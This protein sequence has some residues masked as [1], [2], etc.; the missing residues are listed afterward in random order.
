M[1]KRDFYEVLGVAKGA[2][3]KALKSAFRKQAMKYHPDR[4]PDDADA[5]AKFKEVNEAYGILSDAQKRAA[6]DRMGHAAFEGGMGSGGMGGGNPFGGGRSG[7]F[8]GFGDIFEEMFGGSFG[9]RGRGGRQRQQR[10]ADTSFK[11]DL[12]LEEAHQGLKKIFKGSDNRNLH[13]L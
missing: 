13:G 5:E 1:A 6:Y 10:G 12:T 3:E 9:G 2:D 11:I 4:N 8:D 7:G